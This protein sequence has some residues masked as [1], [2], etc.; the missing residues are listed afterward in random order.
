M[1]DRNDASS[2]YAWVTQLPDGGTCVVGA[3]IQEAGGRLAHQPLINRDREV[4]EL[5]RPLARAHRKTTGQRVWLREYTGA[6][7]HG[8]A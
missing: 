4:A 1:T 6:I 2:L 3:F 8:D 5:L 7:D